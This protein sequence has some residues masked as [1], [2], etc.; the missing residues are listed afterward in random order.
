MLVEPTARMTPKEYLEAER[1]ADLKS[2]YLAGEVFAM[3]GAGESHN[4]IVA[5]LIVG[6]GTQLRKRPCRVYPSDMRVL[7]RETGLYTYPDVA[8]VCGEPRFLDDRRD[9]LLNPTLLVEVLS[10]S[11]EAYDRGKKFEHYREIESLQE[12]LLVSPTEPSLERFL[13]QE[14]GT[15][16][17][18]EARGLGAA[19]ELASIGCT[20]MLAEVYEKVEGIGAPRVEAP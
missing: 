19:A 4:L 9:T 20:L 16:L 12:Y 18:S 14:A 13:R 2:E 11:T 7:V 5:N 15:W 10:E 1:K 6:L 3:A 8:V 17:F